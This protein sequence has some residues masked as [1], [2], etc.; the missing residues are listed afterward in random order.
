M[1]HFLGYEVGSVGLPASISLGLVDEV[2]GA[3]LFPNHVIGRPSPG[4]VIP[5]PSEKLDPTVFAPVVR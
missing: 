1:G 4:G 3:I 5:D 2:G